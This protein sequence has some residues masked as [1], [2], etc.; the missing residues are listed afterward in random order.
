MEEASIRK[1]IYYFESSSPTLSLDVINSVKERLTE[2]DA[3]KV[4]V[5][6]TTGK[7]AEEFQRHIAP[8]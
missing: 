8:T 3:K 7:T 5:P 4:I 1:T 2:G 6:V